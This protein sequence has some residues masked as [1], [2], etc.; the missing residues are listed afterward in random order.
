MVSG[1][2]QLGIADAAKGDQPLAVLGRFGG[3]DRGQNALRF[4]QGA[5]IF[6]DQI[7]R[8]RFVKLTGHQQHR[9][10][11]LVELVIEGLQ[12]VDGHILDI[13]PRAERVIA[14]G[15]ATWDEGLLLFLKRRGFPEETYHTFSYSPIPG[16]GDGNLG[17]GSSVGGMLCVVTEDTERTIGERRHE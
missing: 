12:P 5:E 4:L 8:L 7:Q 11:R 15:E 13:G 3:V 9:V 2:N 6:V 16:D 17:N 1:T 14:S 10:I